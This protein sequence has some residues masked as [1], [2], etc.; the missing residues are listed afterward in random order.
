M[1][2]H[3]TALY[4]RRFTDELAKRARHVTSTDF[5]ESF[6]KENERVNGPK[7]S[8]VTFRTLDATK[9]DCP[10]DSFDFV[11]GLWLLQFLSENEVTEFLS[12]ILR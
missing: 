8:N 7:H 2:V 12:K 1:S 6:V 3:I 5:M 11:I 9:L 4:N 10:P